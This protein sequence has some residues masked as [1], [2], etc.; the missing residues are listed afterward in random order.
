[1]VWKNPLTDVFDQF[2]LSVVYDVVD[3]ELMAL[4]GTDCRINKRCIQCILEH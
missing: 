1:M 2:I 3:I 4:H